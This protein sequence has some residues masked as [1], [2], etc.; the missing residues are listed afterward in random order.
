MNQASP[1]PGQD[2]SEFN[3]FFSNSL[4][5]FKISL[6]SH[7][8]SKFEVCCPFEIYGSRQEV[9]SKLLHGRLGIDQWYEMFM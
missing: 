5:K 4:R 6:L 7:I 1:Y 3:F 9:L 2:L 8:T